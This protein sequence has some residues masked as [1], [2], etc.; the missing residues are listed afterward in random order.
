MVLD[1]VADDIV[2]H[3]TIKGHNLGGVAVPIYLI[4][5]DGSINRDEW[6]SINMCL[7]QWWSS[8]EEEMGVVVVVVV[9]V[10]EEEEAVVVM[11]S[12]SS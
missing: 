7:S 10:V 11:G 4:W 3:A 9:T 8:M 12:S 1:K 6:M 5:M 2:L